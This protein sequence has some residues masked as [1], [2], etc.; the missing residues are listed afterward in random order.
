MCGIL[1]HLYFIQTFLPRYSICLKTQLVAIL[2]I[3]FVIW[4]V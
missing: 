1:S 2:K 4:G 3:T